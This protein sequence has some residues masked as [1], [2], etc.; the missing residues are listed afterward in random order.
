MPL[1]RI[2]G[3]QL[4]DWDRFH[5]VFASAFGFPDYYGRNMDAWID[6]MSSLDAREQG[7]TS[8]HGSAADPVVV[9]LESA[10]VVPKDIFDALV[11]CAG[12]VD[13]RR[14]KMGDPA[15]LV[16]SFSRAG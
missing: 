9:H 7:M 14:L 10:D 2:N 5:S 16:L 12:F 13:W 11:E 1:I 15:I 4:C 3:A 6:C 8:V